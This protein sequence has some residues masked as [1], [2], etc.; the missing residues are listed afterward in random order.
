MTQGWLQ[1]CYYTVLTSF[2]SVLT[3]FHSQEHTKK[4]LYSKSTHCR[5][6]NLTGSHN[7]PAERSRRFIWNVLKKKVIL[8]IMPSFSKSSIMSMIPNTLTLTNWIVAVTSVSWRAPQTGLSLQVIIW[9]ITSWLT[10]FFPSVLLRLPEGIMGKHHNCPHSQFT[11]FTVCWILNSFYFLQ[12]CLPLFCS[13]IPPFFPPLQWTL[14]W[15]HITRL[16]LR[17]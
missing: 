5:T 3:M 9:C 8:Q 11:S 2:V 1:T 10:F 4:S 7:L 14:I 13:F 16:P 15:H 12:V 6:R 17:M